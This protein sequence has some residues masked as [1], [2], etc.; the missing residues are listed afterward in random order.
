M[1]LDKTVDM[2]LSEDHKERFKAEYHQLTYRTNKLRAYLKDW[3]DGK[4]AKDKNFKPEHP[5][6]LLKW[7]LRTME[8]YLYVLKI[9]AEIENIDL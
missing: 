2:M 9:R 8:D 3:S 7:Q 1:V 5:Y 6:Y 4:L